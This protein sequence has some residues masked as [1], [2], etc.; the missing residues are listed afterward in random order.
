MLRSFEDV[1]QWRMIY[2]SIHTPAAVKRLLTTGEESQTITVN[3][4]G[5]YSVEVENGNTNNY[6]MD[7]KGI[8]GC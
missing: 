2:Q 3:E 6:S 8:L 1:P 7:F 4:S 5:D